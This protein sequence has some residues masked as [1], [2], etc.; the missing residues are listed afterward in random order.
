MPAHFGS[1]VVRRKFALIIPV[2]V[3]A[4]LATTPTVTATSSLVAI[5]ALLTAFVWIVQTTYRNAQPAACPAQGPHRADRATSP[6][7]DRPRR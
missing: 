7:H 3:A 5:L 4:W 2:I 6:A 1:T